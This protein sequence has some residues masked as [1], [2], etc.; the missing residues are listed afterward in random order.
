MSSVSVEPFV[1]AVNESDAR[2]R[3][4]AH[5]GSK[6]IGYFCTYTLG[7]IYSAQL[8]NAA[9]K[10]LGNLEDM[11]RKGE[12]QSLFKWLNEKIHHQGRRY[13][14]KDLVE[15]ATGEKPDPNYLI[16]YLK[17]KYGKLYRF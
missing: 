12:Y 4:A 3:K 2:L 5:G 10:E 8:Y 1:I 15:F 6:I 17:R 13:H 14:P 16:G 11:F 7:N 9:E